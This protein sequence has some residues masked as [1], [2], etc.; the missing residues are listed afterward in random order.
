MSHKKVI[1]KSCVR[2]GSIYM[3]IWWLTKGE[4]KSETFEHT[5]VAKHL[6]RQSV[7]YFWEGYRREGFEEANGGETL[8]QAN[9]EY[10]AAAGGVGC[11]W[12]LRC[13]PLSIRMWH[14][15]LWNTNSLLKGFARHGLSGFARQS[16]QMVCNTW[17]VKSLQYRNYH[18]FVRH[19][20]QMSHKKLIFKRF[21]R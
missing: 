8:E 2:H 16:G 3:M 19:V 5:I 17:S 11:S 6:R 12:V 18:A 15:W 10:S 1:V 13:A 9:V 14:W 4:L 20:L 21:A 7:R